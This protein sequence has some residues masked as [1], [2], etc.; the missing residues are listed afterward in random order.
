M[1]SFLKDFYKSDEDTV[2]GQ[3]EL[4]SKPL[5][6]LKTL[7]NPTPL[8]ERLKLALYGIQNIKLPLTKNEEH[9]IFK[10]TKDHITFLKNK[11]LNEL[12]DEL[13]DETFF[14][15]GRSIL[16]SLVITSTN[17]ENI[18]KTVDFYHNY[19]ANIFFL[20]C[21][22]F[23]F[24]IDNEFCNYLDEILTKFAENPDF[25]NKC[26]IEF[27]NN[28]KDDNNENNS[29]PLWNKIMEET[30]F[31]KEIK[32][33][34]IKLFTKEQIIKDFNELEKEN[35]ELFNLFNEIFKYYD[36]S[37]LNQNYLDY[38][39]LIESLKK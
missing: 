38:C 8:E 33:R 39:Y 25:C 16:I 15:I 24:H 19:I 23:G 20:F 35:L 32:K 28:Y 21:L 13:T 12:T 26:L 4:E 10:T 9:I 5:K 36:N 17:D 29:F 27:N 31:A 3:L 1:F 22:A 7:I 14:E 6:M 34:Q 11:Y 30:K 37:F 18:S 2:E